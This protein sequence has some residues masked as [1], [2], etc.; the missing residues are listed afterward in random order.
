MHEPE[1]ILP[2]ISFDHMQVVLRQVSE[3]VA[4]HLAPHV[5]DEEAPRVAE[6][7]ARL[8][9][10]YTLAPTDNVDVGDEESARRLVRTFVLP[11]LVSSEVTSS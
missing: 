6:W 5:G 3:F 7:V 4:P 8:V 9:L 1:V 10:T 2:R 11:G